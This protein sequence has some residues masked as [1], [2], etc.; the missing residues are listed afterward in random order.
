[1]AGGSV[2]AEQDYDADVDSCVRTGLTRVLH[3]ASV[4][5]RNQMIWGSAKSLEPVVREVVERMALTEVRPVEA[6]GC[7]IT[8]NN[9]AVIAVCYLDQGK[10]PRR[11]PRWD[12]WQMTDEGEVVPLDGFALARTRRPFDG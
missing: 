6:T 3:L 1:M 4:E 11:T 5:R 7:R 2:W 10:N 8:L 9:G 12:G